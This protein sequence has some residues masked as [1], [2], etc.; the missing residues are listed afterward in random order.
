[1]KIVHITPYYPPH[2]GGL[3][4]T[5]KELAER[6]AQMGYV[7]S[8]YTSNKC[9][10][11]KSTSSKYHIYV[12]RLKS[13]ELPGIP[14][15]L[16]MLP[17]KLLSTIDE[18]TIVHVHYILNFSMDIAVIISKIKKAKIVV[19]VHIDPLPSGPL[20]FLNPTYKKLFWRRIL[21]L[22]DIVICPT[23]DYIDIVSDKY[24]V[25]SD[26]CVII[27]SGIDTKKF[28][29]IDENVDHTEVTDLLFV[30]RLSKQKNIPMLLS[31]L[32]L[33][34]DKYDLTLHIVG[35][36]EERL[37]IRSMIK[38]EKLR[39]VVLHGRVS[40][41]KLKKL[42]Q[43]SDIFILTSHQESFGIVL[44]EAMASGLPV[45]ASDIIGVRN[46]VEDSGLLVKPTS[47]NFASAIIKL[48]ED[49]GLRRN[50]I[51][52]GKEKV[53]DYDWGEIIEEVIGAYKKVSESKNGRC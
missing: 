9:H 50:L 26:K 24:G 25:D 14:L 52:K 40:D 39:N 32:K 16:P 7:V 19:H 18:D 33:I 30:G 49:D 12:Y 46:V 45:V 37:A 51:R 11:E 41:M 10:D 20:G 34:Q 6:T 13:I 42:Y 23:A 47:E 8:V 22:S 1:M 36:G 5:V 27:P 17:F 43:S 15:M 29:L 3:E 21:P 38:K 4:N 44:I 48:I 35:D 53:K 31:T 28:S 2:T